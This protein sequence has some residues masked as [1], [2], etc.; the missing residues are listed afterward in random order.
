[1]N[2]ET[3]LAT[4]LD[5]WHKP[6]VF[7]DANHIIQYM[8]VPAQRHYAQWGTVIGKSIFDCH[9]D[10]SRKIIQDAYRQLEDGAEE[11][12]FTTNE[13]HRVYMRGVRDSKGT[14]LGYIERYEPPVG[15]SFEQSDRS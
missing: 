6:I 3:L 8:N 9:N 1:M 13:K 11:V 10:N 14:L 4:I 2:K 5:N 7:V 15:K 12:L